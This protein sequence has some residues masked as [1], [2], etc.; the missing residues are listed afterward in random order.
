L[1]DPSSMGPQQD[2]PCGAIPD[3]GTTSI[4]GPPI[5]ILKLFAKI[6]DA[7]PRCVRTTKRVKVL[8]R[9]NP[10]VAI[11]FKAIFFMRLIKTCE[12]FDL[13]ELPKIK[14]QLTGATDGEV[15]MVEL[16]GW[17][18]I[19]ETTFTG[20]NF[21]LQHLTEILP[22]KERASLL[23]ASSETSAKRI[24]TPAFG[25]MPMRTVKNGDVWI[26]GTP[27][28]YAYSVHYNMKAKGRPS[29]SFVSNSKTPCGSCESGADLMA[30]DSA[31]NGHPR[32]V[33]GPWR[34]PSFDIQDEM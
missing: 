17:H 28:F 16:A 14:F 8:K 4:M 10:F 11:R 26:M 27:L 22:K 31:E 25:H 6:C 34:L 24:C 15:Q 12:K 23:Q 3:S 32:F 9:I 19:M 20:Y 1:C 29:M 18:Y 7:W 2:T 5:G 13:K 33:D 30:D 21:A